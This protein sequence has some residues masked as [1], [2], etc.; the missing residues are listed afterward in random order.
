METDY[1][2]IYST[3]CIHCSVPTELTNYATSLNLCGG[4]R[5]VQIGVPQNKSY[6]KVDPVFTKPHVVIEDDYGGI[7][8]TLLTDA[9]I[10]VCL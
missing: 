6:A 2:G 8:S 3:R 1:G 4:S 7:Y 10:A 9:S 5:R